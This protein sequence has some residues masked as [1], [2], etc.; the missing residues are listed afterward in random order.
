MTRIAIAIALFTPSSVRAA[1]VFNQRLSQDH[2]SSIGFHSGEYG[3]RKMILAPVASISYRTLLSLC[4]A[5]LSI[6]TWCPGCSSG[7]STFST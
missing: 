5:R 7:T 3:G 6:T 2:A 4:A 1:A